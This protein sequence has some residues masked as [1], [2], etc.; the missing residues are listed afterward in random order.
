MKAAA[1]GPFWAALKTSINPQKSVSNNGLCSSGD[2]T[3]KAPIMPY[4]ALL[5]RMSNPPKVS[6]AVAAA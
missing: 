1:I 2:S 3:S 5:T 4:P 6:T